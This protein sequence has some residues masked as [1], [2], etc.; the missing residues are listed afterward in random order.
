MGGTKQLNQLAHEKRLSTK[1]NVAKSMSV[2]GTRGRGIKCY[3]VGLGAGFLDTLFLRFT[4]ST[5]T[6]ALCALLFFPK[7]TQHYQMPVR[8]SFR[9]TIPKCALW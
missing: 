3:L 4:K 8:S 7:N 1:P 2:L 5:K 9:P 6:R